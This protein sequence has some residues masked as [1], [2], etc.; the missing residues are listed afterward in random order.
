[1]LSSMLCPANLLQPILAGC[2]LLLSE[3]S[4]A[5]WRYERDRVPDVVAYRLLFDSLALKGGDAVA[6]G[7]FTAGEVRS[8]ER[9]ARQFHSRLRR[10][11]RETIRTRQSA[12]LARQRRLARLTRLHRR[13]DEVTRVFLTSLNGRLGAPL[14]AKLRQYCDDHVKTTIAVFGMRRDSKE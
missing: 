14:A 3:A 7:P 8:L 11:D 10:V 12:D 1:M 2:A 5:T 4:P 6:G 9:V 13:R